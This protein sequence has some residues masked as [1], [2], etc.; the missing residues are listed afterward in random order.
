MKH[1]KEIIMVCL[2][3]LIFVIGSIY[4]IKDVS[5]IR[6]FYT[7]RHRNNV[8]MIQTWMTLHYIS[9]SYDV[10]EQVLLDATHTTLQQARHQSLSNLA[11]MHMESPSHVIAIVSAEILHYKAHITVTP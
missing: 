5:T 9:S 11:K 2:G 7:I 4:L 8:N 6:H 10:P 1:H 3:V